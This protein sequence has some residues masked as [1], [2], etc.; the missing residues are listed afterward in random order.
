MAIFAVAYITIIM[1]TKEQLIEENRK[2]LEKQLANHELKEKFYELTGVE[3]RLVSIRDEHL[4]NHPNLVWFR[5]DTLA[6]AKAIADKC[7]IKLVDTREYGN[8]KVKLFSPFMLTKS[9]TPI[10]GDENPQI[11]FHTTDNEEVMIQVPW[12]CY[13]GHIGWMRYDKFDD[14]AELARLRKEPLTYETRTLSG[15]CVFTLRWG[16]GYTENY[17]GTQEDREEFEKLI[18]GQD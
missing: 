2:Q 4:P 5:V 1:K 8:K 15:K 3:P 16:G 9:R 13:E 14:E 11:R 7:Q 10:S 18:F 6:Q 12:S 17:C